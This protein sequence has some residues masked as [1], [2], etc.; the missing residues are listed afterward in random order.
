LIE[1]FPAIRSVGAIRE[2]P[3]AVI[4]S[5][6][7]GKPSILAVT[8]EFIRLQ[9]LELVAGR[10]LVEDDVRLRSPVCVIGEEVAHRLGR[11]GRP[12]GTLRVESA[13]YRVV[14]VL[15]RTGKVAHEGTAVAARDFDNAIMI[16]LGSEAAF[17]AA[18][19][20]VSEIVAEFYLAD[21]VLPALPAVR[22][23]LA[24]AHSGVEDVQVVAPQEL[25]QQAEQAQRNFLVLTGSI[26]IVAL[27]VGGIGIMNTMLASV[28]ERTREIG[29]RR[30]VGATRRHIM[31]Q[32]LSEAALL[33][34]AGGAAGLVLGI[35]ASFAVSAIA[36]W[37]VAITAWSLV[38]PAV[39]A[40]VAGVFFG[41]YPAYT[42]ARMDPVEALRHV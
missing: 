4:E 34:A 20:A 41:V 1:A 39:V 28:T 3:G 38:L 23:T 35:A 9:G 33:T 22:R 5:G 36:G 32:F 25:L 24:V 40:I 37:P 16:P 11:E 6:H 27:L 14:G 10:L 19:D 12:G 31:L 15:R 13:L 8:P 30:A 2:L 29:V 42:A 7:Q 17:V 21:A 26:A 18:G